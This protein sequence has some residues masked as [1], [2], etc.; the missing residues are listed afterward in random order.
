MVRDFFGKEPF[1]GI[2]PDECVAMGAAIQGG[3]LAGEI[4]DMVLIDVTPLTLGIET[5]G[6]VMTRMIDR[7]TR[8]PTSKKRIFSTAAMDDTS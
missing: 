5:L 8:I 2:N 3:I 1:K 6:G 7:N 4:D